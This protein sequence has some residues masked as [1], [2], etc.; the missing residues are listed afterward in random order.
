M[1]KVLGLGDNV[2]DIYL[3]TNT[4]YPGGQALNVAVYAKMLGTESDFLGVN[5]T[6]AVAAHVLTTLDQKGIGHSHSRITD[7]E[8]GFACVTLVNGDR[9]FKGSNR[10]GVLQKTPIVLD[11]N[12]LAYIDGFDVVHTT[13]NGFTDAQMPELALQNPLLSYDFSYRWNEPDRVDWI[14]PFIDFGFLSCGGLT[15]HEVFALCKALC[16][17]GCGVVVATRGS[18]GAF[19]YDGVTVLHQKPRRV[20]AVDTMGAGDSFA[21]C[22]LVRVAQALSK[23]GR[24]SWREAAFRADTLRKA[25]ADAA[26]FASE[27][28]LTSGAFGCGAPVPD[29]LRPAIARVLK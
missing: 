12:D 24:A 17:K 8:N 18:L 13:N 16:D 28:C 23:G 11:E 2:C 4:M 22:T 21:A 7:G 15:D 19:V 6:D 1:V 9:V 27:T 10:G 25:L 29:S 3:H 5:G 26:V 14:C 20:Q